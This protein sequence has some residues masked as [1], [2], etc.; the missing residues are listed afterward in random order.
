[1]QKVQDLSVRYGVQSIAVRRAPRFGPTAGVWTNFVTDAQTG[2]SIGGVAPE[3]LTFAWD[4]DSRADGKLA[5]NR[6]LVNSSSPSSFATQGAQNDEEAAAHDP[7]FPCCSERRHLPQPHVLQFSSI[8]FGARTPRKE[9]FSGAGGWWTWA[10]PA[11]PAIAA[12]DPTYPGGHVALVSPLVSMLLGAV[13]LLDPA[14]DAQLELAWDTFPGVL[15]FEAYDG[16]QLISQQSADLHTAGS[17]TL[18][19]TTSAASRGISRLTARVLVDPPPAVPAPLAGISLYRIAYFTM[20]DLKRYVADAQRCKSPGRVGPPGSD[21]SGK[22]AFLPNHDYEIVVTSSVAMSAKDHGTRTLQTSEALY[23]RT[24]GLPGLNAC[25][26]VGDDIRRHVDMSYPA[27]RATPLYRQEPCVLA[28]ENSL[29]SI[30]PIDRAPGPSDPPEKAQMFPLELNIDR[31]AS[32]SGLKRL[33]V[34]SYDWILAHR[35][36]PYS[37]VHSVAEPAYARSKV[38]F[39]RSHDPLVQRH[40]AV[41]TA[42]TTCGPPKLDHASQVLL[43]EP[44]DSSGNP[45]LWEAGTGYRATVRQQGG[46]FAERSGFD[47]Y[48]LG[49]FIMQADGAAAVRLW[50]VDARGNLVAPVSGGRRRRG[51]RHYAS[52]GELGWDHLRVHARIDLATAHAAGIAVGVGD[53]TRVP[54]CVLATVEPDGGGHSLIVRIRDS[55]GDRELGRAAVTITGPFLLQVIAYDDLVRAVV[56]TV[57][58]DGPRGAVRE[59]RVAL[60][61]DGPATFAGISVGAL[62]IYSF[63]F[64]TSKY[65]SFAE[66]LGSYDGRLPEMAAGALGGTPTPIGTVLADHTTDLSAVMSASADPQARQRLFDVIV[67]ALGAGL[68]KNPIAVTITRLTDASGTFGLAVESPEAI[69]LTR[70]V[71]VQLIHHVRV[72]VPAPVPVPVP[73]LT[74]EGLAAELR[75]TLSGLVTPPAPPAPADGEAGAP[76]DVSSLTFGDN[77]VTAPQPLAVLEPGD[78]VARVVADP[79]GTVIHVYDPPVA[80][81]GS[82]AVGARRETLTAAQA[83][84]QPAYSS[85]A[86]LP[87]GSVV[88]VRPGGVIGPIGHGHWIWEDIVVPVTVLTNGDETKTLILSAAPLG[89]GYFTLQFVLDRDR[90]PVSTGSDPEQHYHDQSTIQLH[91]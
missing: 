70:E 12:G 13:D 81:A 35:A 78:Q 4:V 88:V 29:S 36:N 76:S 33:T 9:Q 65:A 64:V 55:A 69:S 15:Y 34:P 14:F 38:R 19:L 51:G 87:P 31:V 63:E 37:P 44:I 84:Q 23:F 73:V 59:G 48:D 79:A 10:L 3:S 57:S 58:V 85:V 11:P 17:A 61:A 62:D 24:K 43:H 50:S 53:G 74:V 60:V 90:W 66:H 67:A 6:L 7:D 46:P 42:V 25:Q 68:R 5:P 72:W 1:M 41:Q 75:G 56:G 8:P 16:V 91:W 40:E 86:N 45:G 32:L 27:R 82:G 52:C 18:Q 80:G 49:A 30:L 83:A 77:Q 2:F 71:T 39:T 21:A 89:A 22:L 54:Q 47:I 20:A 28:F 26:N